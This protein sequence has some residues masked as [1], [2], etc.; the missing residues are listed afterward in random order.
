MV[1]DGLTKA[2][3]FKLKNRVFDSTTDPH[4]FFSKTPHFGTPYVRPKIHF[5]EKHTHIYLFGTVAGRATVLGIRHGIDG[6]KQQLCGC[7]D[8]HGNFRGI[9]SNG[10]RSP[11]HTQPL[12][13]VLAALGRGGPHRGSQQA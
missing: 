8:P 10:R 1:L 2:K 13:S 4:Q 9:R 5:L 11:C 7:V 3:P 6:H 12:G